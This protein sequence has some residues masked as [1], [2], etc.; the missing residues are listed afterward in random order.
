[1][2]SND[3][4]NLASIASQY[5]N[6]TSRHIFLTG[7]AG[8]GKTTFL[9]S[10]VEKTHKKCVVAAPTGIAAINAGGVTLH[11]L[12]QLPFGCFI[13][14]ELPPGMTE[15]N[16]E[17]N[18]PKSIGS[19]RR[20][21]KTKLALLR[22]IELL[23]IDEVSMLRAD[24]LDAIDAMLR[25]VRRQRYIPFGGVQML[26]IGDLLQLPPVVKDNEWRYLAP[27]YKSAYF[28]EAHALKNNQPVYIEL[29]KIYRQTDQDFIEL[30]GRFRDNRPTTDDLDLL[31]LSFSPD[32]T[33]KIDE[34]YIFITTHNFKADEKNG[35][36]LN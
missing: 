29:E 26:F 28:F 1:M 2:I 30:L 27:F 14:A 5:A 31:N 32:Y 22:E 15:I 13:P 17:I 23:V 21:N 11:S 36:A 34:G 10:F 24:L 8:T 12:L 19:S 33:K 4:E 20:I 18:T 25:S 35:N 16:T 3:S 6:S 9:R 7:R